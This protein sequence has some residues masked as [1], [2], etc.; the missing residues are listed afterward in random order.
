MAT[1]TGGMGLGATPL[2]PSKMR[3]A[4]QLQHSPARP[5][6]V[7]AVVGDADMPSL[8]GLPPGMMLMRS[9]ATSICGS[10]F[11]GNVAS[12]NPSWRGVLDYFFFRQGC[13]GGSGHEV[14]AEVVSVVEPCTRKP[15]DL[16][17][18]MTTGYLHVVDSVRQ[19]FEK[20]TNFSTASLPKNGSFSEYFVSYEG[21]SVPLPSTPPRFPLGTMLH[22]VAAQPLGTILH[23]VSKLTAAVAQMGSLR[24]QRVAIVGQGQNGLLMTHVLSRM[25][26]REII[27]CDRIEGRLAV[28]RHAGASKVLR[29]TGL[30]TREELLKLAGGPVDAALETVGRVG[31][32]ANTRTAKFELFRNIA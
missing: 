1:T 14:V 8:D 5:Y 19:A 32:V 6:A 12:D 25:G 7:R 16:L 26:C 29:L 18:A 15:G 2:I 23:A 17:L 10:D 31:E 9:V 30:E 3:A 13:T 24:D 20:R 21:I 4:T 27:A 28:A 11:W 22:Y